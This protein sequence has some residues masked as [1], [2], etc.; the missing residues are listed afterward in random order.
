MIKVEPGK[1]ARVNFVV[2]VGES[3]EAVLDMAAKYINQDIIPEEFNLAATRSR[4]EARYLNLKASEIEFYQELLSHILFLSPAQRLRKDCIANNTKGQ[5]GLWS[6]GISGDLPI[7]LLTLEK[8]DDID[9][10]YD[11]LKAHEYW[12]YKNLKVDL[13]ILNEE[14]NSYANPLQG[15]LADILS[16]SHAHDMINKPGGVF[17]LKQSN[18]PEEDVNLICAAAR[19]VLRGGAGDLKEQLYTKKDRYVPQLKEYKEEAKK[20]ESKYVESS[21][22]QF[23]NGI[24]GF[25]N[26]G[27]EYEIVLKSGTTTPLPWSNVISNRNFGFIVTE[28]GGGYTWHENSRENKLTPWS[29]DPVSDAPGEIIYVSDD[30]TG[31]VWN[32]TALPIRENETYTAVH[33]FGYSIFRNSSHGFE[34]E[35]TQFVPVKDNIKLSLVKMKNTSETARKLSLYYYIRPVLGVSDQLTSSYISTER[36][37]SGAIL[38]RNTY[39]EEFAGRITYV[40][41]SAKDRTFTC[42]RK[43]FLAGGTL[44]NPPGIR[45]QKLSETTGAGLDPCVVLA[46]V[47]NFNPGEEKEIVFA[48]GE[49]NSLHEVETCINKYRKVDAVKK[50]LR[51]IK[52][53]WKDKLEVLQVSTPDKAMDYMLNG[54]LMYQ[55]L[56]CRM[57]T[58]SGFYQSGGAYGFRDQLQDC[59]SVAHIIPDITKDQIL[60]HS[61]HQFIEGDVQHWWHEPKYKGTRTRFSDDLL[62][63]PYVTAEYI[64]IT[65]DSDILKIETP[66]LEDDPLKDF[67]DESY[68]IP[69]VSEVKS[70]LYDHCIR[71]IERSL[72]FGEHGIPLIGSGDWNDGMN[73]VGNKGK[74]ESIWLGWFMHSILMKFAPICRSMGEEELANKYTAVAEE[75]VKSIEENAWDGNWYRRAY[76]DD[77]RPLGSIQNTE[78]QIDSLAQS[79]A[80]ISGAGNKERINIAMNSL[81]NYLVKR[82]E[83]L[84][85]LLTPSFDEGDLEPGY[86][87]SYV[88]GVRENGGQ[89]THAACWVVMAFAMMGDGDKAFELFNLINPINHAK[90]QIEL[91][92]YKVEPYVISADVYSVEPHIGRG[93]WSWYTGAAGW[94][95]RIGIEYIL[96]F[97]KNGESLSIDPC[98]PKCWGEFNIKYKYK[99]TLY[100]F[101]IKNPEGVNKGVKKLVLDGMELE[102][103]IIALVDDNK[104]HNGEVILGTIL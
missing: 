41:T 14:E 32:I 100:N 40:D 13:V 95:Y 93:G 29:N 69:R 79:W 64:R 74:G 91:A 62:W 25:K 103:K 94:M 59:L 12:K 43:E 45:S 1:M 55:V 39:N 63:M 22:I 57:W 60:L 8:T 11:L 20:Y 35:L 16:S 75:I 68:R 99:N 97:K 96:G 4:V 84:I 33:G 88:P 104:E 21:D 66:F 36:H 78:C 54:W 42:D 76:F 77:G 7:V 44:T 38:I 6:Y 85:K 15:L 17:V 70:T 10:V 9:I 30:N 92:K 19:V 89:Y 49:E 24:G 51:E 65:G 46:V 31:E 56:S 34:Q 5:S 28:S 87:K 98:I 26:E 52:D 23:F 53:F 102:E 50:A 48:L 71:A 58:R 82:D 27:K 47:V 90:S 83:G 3:R 81:E 80:V 2:A 67:E 37:D 18:L 72:K 86:I 61:K 101:K 73:T